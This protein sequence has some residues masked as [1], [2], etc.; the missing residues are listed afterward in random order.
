[1]DHKL[2]GCSVV[3]FNLGMHHMPHTGDLPN[4]VFSTA[5]SAMLIEPMNYL[6][7]DPSLASSQQVLIKTTDGKPE[8]TRYGAKEATCPVDL[9]QLNP[10]LSSYSNS[11]SVL[12][13]PFDGS[14]PDRA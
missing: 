8:I 12:K 10:D 1:M 13:Y 7:G 4:T 3:W 5:H 9:A 11:V 2:T 6:L 14:K